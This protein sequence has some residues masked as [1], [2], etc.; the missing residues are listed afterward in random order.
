VPDSHHH[1]FFK[2]LFLFNRPQ[3][4]LKKILSKYILRTREENRQKGVFG[5]LVNLHAIVLV[6]MNFGQATSLSQNHNANA[7]SGMPLIKHLR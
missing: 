3:K 6:L 2:D 7:Y 4:A 1:F 5:L